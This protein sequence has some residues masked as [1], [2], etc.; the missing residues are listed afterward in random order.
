MD[1]AVAPAAVGSLSCDTDVGFTKFDEAI[2]NNL[3][4]DQLK[5]YNLCK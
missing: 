3:H 1:N 4:L 5:Q 2:M